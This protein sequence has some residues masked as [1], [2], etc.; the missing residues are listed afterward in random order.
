MTLVAAI[1]HL[2]QC[3][4]MNSTCAA[5]PKS[6]AK[7]S[8]RYSRALLLAAFR[9]LP[10]ILPETSSVDVVLEIVS[11]AEMVVVIIV[12]FVLVSLYA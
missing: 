12:I 4:S 7:A 10:Y 11:E 8:D 2:N 9:V 3:L 6:S 5:K 1:I